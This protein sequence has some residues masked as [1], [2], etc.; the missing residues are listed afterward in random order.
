MSTT[1]TQ[2]PSGADLLQHLQET[3]TGADRIQKVAD[4]L[5]GFD[6]E[7]QP[8]ARDVYEWALTAF[9]AGQRGTIEKIGR[10]AYGDGYRADLPGNSP[11]AN[12]TKREERLLDESRQKDATIKEKDAENRRLMAD[13]RRLRDEN[14]RLRQRIDG[15]EADSARQ[16]Q[17]ESPARRGPGRPRRPVESVSAPEGD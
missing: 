5:A 15:L 16:Q 7:A 13:N 11:V 14:F 6:E 2:T 17:T 1:A 9:P 10:F 12:Q 4:Y 8:D 3:G